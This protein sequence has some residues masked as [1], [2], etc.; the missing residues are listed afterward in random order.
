MSPCAL[1]LFVNA[2]AYIE[3]LNNFVVPEYGNNTKNRFL[4]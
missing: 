1:K 4:I 3:I 2:L